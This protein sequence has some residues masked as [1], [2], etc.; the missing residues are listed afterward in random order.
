[1][2]K[3]KFGEVYLESLNLQQDVL[4]PK[5]FIH[6]KRDT[7][8]Y[9]QSH[10]SKED[11]KILSR[12]L[13]GRKSL[14]T[15]QK[16]QKSRRIKV[17]LPK[18]KREQLLRQIK[19]LDFVLEDFA[20]TAQIDDSFSIEDVYTSL[21]NST[22]SFQSK[23]QYKKDTLIKEY[24]KYLELNDIVFDTQISL[25]RLLM[26]SLLISYDNPERLER[27]GSITYKKLLKDKHLR[28]ICNFS[29]PK[30]SQKILRL[31]KDDET[32]LSIDIYDA[33]LTVSIEAL[34]KNLNN[35]VLLKILTR[36]RVGKYWAYRRIEW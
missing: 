2:R 35:L 23:N 30:T 15:Q 27:S 1:M 26:K 29:L 33:Y 9:L 21:F 34:R 3:G 11:V 22:I 28:N 14:R 25:D 20:Q 19:D 31:F 32:I 5:N 7:I 10:F 24:E 16:E 18:N 36:H 6:T 17:E 8:R 12:E 4:L 13:L